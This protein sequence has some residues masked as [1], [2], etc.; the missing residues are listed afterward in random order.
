MTDSSSSA[1]SYFRR[2]KLEG[3]IAEISVSR[4]DDMQP[5]RQSKNKTEQQ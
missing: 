3:E 4:L 1:H 5:L 2:G